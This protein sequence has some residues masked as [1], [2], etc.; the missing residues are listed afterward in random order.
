MHV[1]P[2]TQIN[3]YSQWVER[4]MLAKLDIAVTDSDSLH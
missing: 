3:K 2:I 1:T 4:L